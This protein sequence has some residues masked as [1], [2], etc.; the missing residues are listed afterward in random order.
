MEIADNRQ[1]KRPPGWMK[2]YWAKAGW[3]AVIVLASFLVSLLVVDFGCGMLLRSVITAEPIVWRIVDVVLDVFIAAGVTLY[4]AV[5]EGYDKRIYS[6]KTVE[7]G[8]VLFALMQLP[9][10]LLFGG[11]IYVTGHL[12]YSLASLIYYGNQSIFEETLGSAPPPLILL[13]MVAAIPLVYMPTMMIG[14]R[15]GVRQYQQEIDEL[16]EDHEKRK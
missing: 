3:Y 4:F 14:T 16:K 1:P 6:V 2:P 8:G 11:A 13:C 7:W 9:V 12:P 5:R 10:S 15:L